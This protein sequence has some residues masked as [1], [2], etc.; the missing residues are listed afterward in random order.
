MEE[1]FKFMI[2][3]FRGSYIRLGRIT[4]IHWGEGGYYM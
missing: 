4:V 1:K 3:K 2:A